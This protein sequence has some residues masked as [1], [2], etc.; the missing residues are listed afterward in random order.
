MGSD[1]SASQIAELI[2]AGDIRATE[3]CE[4]Y[5]SKI[6]ERDPLLKAFVT[7]LEEGALKQAEE[8]DRKRKSSVALPP[9]AGVPIALKDNLCT[10]GVETTCSSKI[11]RNFVPP[12]DA[13]VVEKLRMTGTPVLGK[14]NLD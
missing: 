12:Y 14:T 6:R 10:R 7:I 3:V 5:L 1:S 2:R 13:T 8:V 9:L 4:A 11:L